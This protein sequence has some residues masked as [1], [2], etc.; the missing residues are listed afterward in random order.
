MVAVADVADDH[1]TAMNADAETD[2][3]TQIVAE[4]LVQFPDI[5]GNHGGRPQ[6]LPAGDWGAA[7]QSEQRQQS[8]ADELVGPAAAFD[9]GLRHRAEE[10]V[11]D[12]YRIERQPVLGKPGRAPHV[13]EHAD[14]I[15]L[16]ADPGR[17]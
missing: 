5:G 14:E 3:L 15:A 10:T 12:E 11:D 1:L 6:R 4:E 2:R 7:G 8:V 9:H 16:L 17:V 13:H